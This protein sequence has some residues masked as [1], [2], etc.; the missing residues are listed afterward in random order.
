[1]KT[2]HEWSKWMIHDQIK[3]DEANL[4]KILS[5]ELVPRMNVNCLLGLQ[6]RLDLLYKLI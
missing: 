4:E 5:W 1:M 3:Y 6:A 2:I